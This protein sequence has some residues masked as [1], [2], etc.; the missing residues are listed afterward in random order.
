MGNKEKALWNKKMEALIQETKKLESEIE[1]IKANKI[2]ENAFEWRFEFPEV[3]NE[4][5]A[6]VGFDVVIG[7]PPYGAKLSEDEKDWLRNKFSNQD[8]QLDT[9][10]LFIEQ[11]YTLMRN[12]SEFTFIIPNT[13]LT[14]LKF[15]KIRKFIFENTF[16]H[17]IVHYN[18]AVFEEA[19]VDT[20]IL[21][22]KKIKQANQ[23]VIIKVARDL[24]HYLTSTTSQSNWILN[25]GIPVNINISENES[26][27]K[28][29]LENYPPLGEYV[30]IVVG[31]KPYQKGKGKPKQT[32]EQVKGRVFDT[33]T[34]L[35]KDYYKL[36]RGSDINKY[37]T[38]WKSG[39]WLKYGDHIAE[40]RYTANFFN[41]E[42]IVI[43]Q[44]SD[45]L[46]A[47]IDTEK[48]LCMNNLHVITC[49][50]DDQEVSLKF[51]LG[52]INSKL[53]DFYYTLLN[54]EKGEA[55]AEVKKENLSKL[56][57]NTKNNKIEEKII[58]LVDQIL[59]NKSQNP[60]AD[61]SP[62]ESQIDKLVYQLYDLSEE[63][64]AIVE[65][66]TK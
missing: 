50:K 1:E 36:L 6:F 31:L 47:T 49:F 48:F 38:N 5:G 4:D 44:T 21:F 12:N 19:V 34:K 33:T 54:P 65:A 29:K 18:K 9:Y 64:I 59:T 7:N 40:P 16:V 51:I 39:V 22:F 30:N 20:E 56:P 53:L 28:S 66:S 43:R 27:I 58:S 13:W 55:L 14:N 2:Y 24:N 11:A 25:Q 42:K 62:L 35:S 57:I 15:K 3:L 32:E 61:T 8:Y 37:T 26:L 60:S 46:I 63:E 17:E 23:S 52:L 41:D 10:L 45:K